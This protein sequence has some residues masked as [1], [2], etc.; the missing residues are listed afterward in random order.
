MT[1]SVLGTQLPAGTQPTSLVVHMPADATGS[2]GLYDDVNGGCDGNS[3]PGTACQGLGLAPI[4]NGYATLTTL[5]P[6]LG[7]GVHYIHAAYGGD[8][9][10]TPY[11]SNPVEVTIGLSSGT[12]PP[13]LTAS[14]SSRVGAGVVT[15][16]GDAN[17]FTTVWLHEKSLG[18][19]GFHVVAAKV[20]T[21]EGTYEFHLSITSTTRFFVSAVDGSRSSTVR[22]R[23]ERS[24]E[25]S[26]TQG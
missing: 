12:P 22:A 20:A 10:Y 2:V 8:G 16:R 19:D 9:S 4:V 11:E 13:T 5:S 1:L 15:V 26:S 23:V 7:N 14:A 21:A 18:S 3:G 24:M 6:T 17:P 25:P